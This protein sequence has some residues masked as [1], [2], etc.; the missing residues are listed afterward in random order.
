[1]LEDF[2]KGTFLPGGEP[3]YN[4]AGKDL[5][6]IMFHGL[7]ATPYQV[8]ELGDFLCSKG[9]TNFGARI[10]G[11]ATKKSDLAKTTRKD[12]LDSARKAYEE[13]NKAYPK[14]IVLG[15]SLGGLLAL[16]LGKEYKPQGLITLATPYRLNIKGNFL[17]LIGFHKKHPD[18]MIS[19]PGDIPFKAKYEL[20]KLIKETHEAIKEVKSPI[21]IIQGTA[22]RRVSKDS[23]YQIH[24]QVRSKDKAMMILP[25]EQHIVLKGKYKNQVFDRIYEFILQHN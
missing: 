9:I 18:D 25:G 13:F 16:N 14:T 4:K 5:G 17:S 15:F 24:N 19:Y 6:V 12:W 21:L 1:M 3:F 11:H 20:I 22:D 23:P 7:T 8:K 10:E 2:L